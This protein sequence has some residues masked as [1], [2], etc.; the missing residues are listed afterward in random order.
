MSEIFAHLSAALAGRYVLQRELGRGGMATVYLAQ[1]LR[2]DRPVALKVLHPELAQ[3]LGA[4]RFLREIKLAA[5]LQHPNILSVHDS[6]EAAGQFWFTMPYVEGES[7]R[8]RLNLERQLPLEDALRIAREAA[9]ALYCAHRHGIIHR[10]IKPENILLSEGHALVADFGVSQALRATTP[11]E[12]LTE[13]G[14]VVGTPTYMSPEQGAGERALDARTDVYSLGVVL[15]ELLA[16]EPPYTGPTAQAV[17]AKRF[18]EP[19]P[20]V[21]RTRP[22]VPEPVEHALQ[23]ALAPVPADRYSTAAEFARALSQPASGTTAAAPS[24]ATSVSS[25]GPSQSRRV[26]LAVVLGLGFLLGLGVLFG[27]LRSHGTSEMERGAAPKR[28]AVLPFETVGDTSDRA[29]AAGMSEEISTRLARVPGLSLVAR[30]SALQYP[31]SGQTAPQFGRSLGVDYV[32][33]GTVRSAAGPTGQKQLRITPELIKV[34]DGTHVWGEPYEG[35]TADVFRLQADVAE[36]VAEALRGTL[37]RAE[38]RAVRAGPSNDLEAFRLYTLGRAEWNRRTPASLEHAAEYFHQAIARDSTFARAWAGLADAY[39]LYDYFGVSTLPRDSGYA[40]AKTAA[41]RAIA[42][43]STLAE[44]HASLNQIL[45]YGFWDWAGSEREVRKAIA[46]DPNYATAHKWLAEHLL[47]M[48]R[49]PEAIVEARTAVQL[50]PLAQPTQ[51]TL[52]LTLWYGGRIDEAVATFRAGLARD[53]TAPLL[54]GNLF[55]LYLLS[56]RTDDALALLAA[57][58]D[59][60]KFRGGLLRAR[61]EPQARAVVLEGVRT[62]RGRPS[63]TDAARLYAILGD[64]EAALSALERAAADRSPSLELIKVEPVFASLRGH[65]RFRAIIARMGLPP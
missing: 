50:D 47:T 56:G 36:R 24:V 15:Y 27:W 4:E 16:G 65:P 12:R 7:L 25:P 59:T 20:S 54:R 17:L 52:A 46:L 51:N 19:V 1:D 49:V 37:E 40:R 23:R 34:A 3:S 62:L 38:K 8:Q 43:D 31:R 28:L 30:S 64:R 10:D 11:S 53:F 45:R 57:R 18:S 41:L 22:L 58:Y 26:P 5:R 33:D 29:F 21:R 39:A 63:H 48:G 42:L 13:S 14:M 55:F 32:L 9:E 61:N 60:S 44:P 6:G 35:G 2:H